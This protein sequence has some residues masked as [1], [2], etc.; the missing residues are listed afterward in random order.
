MRC[1]LRCLFAALADCHGQGIMH[2]DVK[3]A[4]FLFNVETNSGT[5]C[6]FGLAQRLNPAEWHARCLH[7]LPELWKR[8]LDPGAAVH[9]TKLARPVDLLTQVDE[10]FNNFFDNEDVIM[11]EVQKRTGEEQIVGPWVPTLGYVREKHL[12][13][14]THGKDN[15]REIREI[16]ERIR[17]ENWKENWAPA[18]KQPSTAK[19]GYMKPEYDKRWVCLCLVCIQALS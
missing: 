3:P 5:L 2:R 16:R 1:Y 13:G 19:V 15:K 8:Y 6:D 7:S 9:G 10:S 17:K 18:L 14:L 12:E 4:N 11:E